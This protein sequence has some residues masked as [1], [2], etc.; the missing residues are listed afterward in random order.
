MKVLLL[1]ALMILSGAACRSTQPA[2]ERMS[3]V[4]SYTSHAYVR[5]VW[6]YSHEPDVSHTVVGFEGDNGALFQ[7]Q[8]YRL[9]PRLWV[10]QHIQMTEDASPTSK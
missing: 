7:L 3:D 4:P 10:G 1:V 5:S 8:F 2:D 6:V 9:E